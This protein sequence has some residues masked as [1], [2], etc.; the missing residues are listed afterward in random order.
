MFYHKYDLCSIWDVLILK[1]SLLFIWNSNI[2]GPPVFYLATLNLEKINSKTGPARTTSPEV[3]QGIVEGV[4]HWPHYVGAENGDPGLTYGLDLPLN[5]KKRWM[6]R[7]LDPYELPLCVHV[8]MQ[9]AIPEDC[10]LCYLEHN[11]ILFEQWRWAS[12]IKWNWKNDLTG[13]VGVL[14]RISWKGSQCW[15]LPSLAGLIRKAEGTPCLHENV[16]DL[17]LLGPAECRPREAVDGLQREI[18]PDTPNP[19]KGEWKVHSYKKQK[20]T[21][22]NLKKQI[23]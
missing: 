22:N 4:V 6:V 17:S 14:F 13:H 1:N 3:S 2:P 12:G 15:R 19:F 11:W 18:F 8:D 16:K 20:Q 21:P 7:C 5:V 9:G 10:M 23:V